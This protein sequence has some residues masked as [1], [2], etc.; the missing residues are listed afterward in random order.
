MRS[1]FVR[2]RFCAVFLGLAIQTLFFFFPQGV[3]LLFFSSRV[4]ERE[5]CSYGGFSSLPLLTRAASHSQTKGDL[6]ED[7]PGLV[8]KKNVLTAT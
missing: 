4:L 3:F 6:Q 7:T 1:V 5:Q 2:L 8:G